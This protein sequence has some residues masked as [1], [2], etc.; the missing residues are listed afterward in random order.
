MVGSGGRC[1]E[2]QC[3]AICCS[4]LQC[5]AVMISGVSAMGWLRLVGSKKL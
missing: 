5:V 4:M 3:L 1:S 2:L